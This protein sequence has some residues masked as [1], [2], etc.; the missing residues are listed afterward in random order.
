MGDGEGRLLRSPPGQCLPLCPTLSKQGCN[1]A[2]AQDP[3][4]HRNLQTCPLFPA[5][6]PARLLP[7]GPP[8]P[9]PYSCLST[10]LWLTSF[11]GAHGVSASSSHSRPQLSVPSSQ[12]GTQ[13]K[14]AEGVCLGTG[15]RLRR[16]L[17]LAGGEESHN[18]A[19]NP[20]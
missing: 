20:E 15:R 5:S 3:L 6:L 17:G 8:V 18:Q 2:P 7:C 13:E 14:N 4:L 11:Q 19:E 1:P 10:L 9:Q 16:Q 12:S